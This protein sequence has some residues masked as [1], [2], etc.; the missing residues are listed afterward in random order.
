[1]KLAQLVNPDW[2]I[3][4]APLRHQVEGLLAA[5]PV[6]APVPP[7]VSVRS[8]RKQPAPAKFSRHGESRWRLLAAISRLTRHSHA[9]SL[10]FIARESGVRSSLAVIRLHYYR[11]RGLVVAYGRRGEYTYALSDLGRKV[12]SEDAAARRER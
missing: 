10:P 2:V 6:P 1:M 11:S 12:L 4:G 9:V 7:P 5:P 3:Q 8:G